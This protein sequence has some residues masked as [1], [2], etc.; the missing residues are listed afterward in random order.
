V[1]RGKTAGDPFLKAV[2]RLRRGDRTIDLHAPHSTFASSAIDEGTLLLLD[3][4]PPGEPRGFLDLGCGYGA[5]GL[6]VALSHPSARGLL[7]DRDLLA[8]DYARRN[9]ER[10]GAA[11]VEVAG[12]LGYRDVPASRAPFDWVL[13]NAPA[14]A[15]DRVLESFIAGGRRRLAP[16]GQMRIV[17]IRA[18][19]P[20]VRSIAARRAFEHSLAAER[21]NH[22]VFAFPAP[23]AGEGEAPPEPLSGDAESL[24]VH[25]R[26]VIDLRL[27]EHLRLTRPTDLA[28]EP[29]R[30]PVA[31]PLLAERLPAEAPARA[32]VFRSGYGL[33]AALLLARYPGARVVATDR[34]LLATAFTRRNC[35][36]RAER[37]DVVES[38][39]LAAA[40]PRGPFDLV[41]GE[42]LSPLGPRS[43]IAELEEARRLLAPGGRALVLGLRKDWP[44]FLRDAGGRLG[45]RIEERRGPVALHA[46]ESP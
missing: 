20:A 1:R 34:D 4:L 39:G 40:A 41:V 13:L 17:V 37:L 31:V 27:P 12:S 5:I 42:M 2:L 45:L 18:L 46:M 43:T 23:G 19:A 15:G 25:D 22:A 35:A 8:V 21:G 30:L 26:D 16:G 14:R 11:S 29:H 44:E 7:V 36:A 38:V 24:E 6:S 32:L 33:L 10:L 9:A 3:H 28:D